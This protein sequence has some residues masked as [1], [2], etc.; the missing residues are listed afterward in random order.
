MKENGGIDRV[1][2]LLCR[3]S[4]LSGCDTS[5]QHEGDCYHVARVT[6][7]VIAIRGSA[8]LR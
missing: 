4:S 2:V 5:L 3:F 6:Q 7:S 1:L 8:N